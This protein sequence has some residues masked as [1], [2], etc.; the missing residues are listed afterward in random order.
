MKIVV[1][2]IVLAALIY[3]LYK[4]T[5]RGFLLS[6]LGVLSIVCSYAG[7]Y[8]FSGPVGAWLEKVT[9]TNPLTA[10]IV[11]GAA[12]FFNIVALFAIVQSVVKHQIRRRRREREDGQALTPSSRTLGGL[13]GLGVAIVMLTVLWWVYDAFRASDFA[14]DFPN[15]S[16]SVFADTARS[17]IRTASGF[18]LRDRLP[19]DQVR[20]AAG[21]LSSPAAAAEQL[22]EFLDEPAMQAL[23]Q[24]ETF[25]EDF[26]SGEADRISENA[27]FVALF[28]DPSASE[29]MEKLGL[30]PDAVPVEIVRKDLAGQLAPAGGRMN[31]VL[32]DPE[33]ILI[34]EELK[35]E[36]AL[37]K[38]DWKTLLFDERIR[39]IAS[40]AMAVEV[41]EKEDESEVGEEDGG[42]SD[43][44][45]SG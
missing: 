37:E 3:Y 36:N 14:K 21:L 44:P 31:A 27:E 4:G 40:R 28:N 35:T 1:D 13:I 20:I 10:R 39:D 26:R 38:P 45:G 23:F 11:A 24:S 6:L 18:A 8:A 43:Q 34:L 22:K 9:G 29:R 32:E 12:I 15:L 42:E 30:I 16:G 7:A 41:E 5:R 25:P 17:I 19:D 2:L 33:V